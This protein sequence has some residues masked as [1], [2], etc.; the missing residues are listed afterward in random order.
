[1]APA[2]R[3][4][5]GPSVP[6]PVSAQAP[7]VEPT[8]SLAALR[9]LGGR[10]PEYRG[11]GL[12]NLVQTLAQACGAKPS[13]LFPVLDA[14]GPDALPRDAPIVLLVLDGVGAAQL[15]ANPQCET[16]RAHRHAE[17]T[18]VFPPTTASAVTTLATGVAA[19]QHGLTGWFI[20]TA[21]CT[22]PLAPLPF[23]LRGTWCDARGAGVAPE[24]VYT[25]PGHFARLS[26][27][28]HVVH[29]D[30]IVDSLYTR[31]HARGA[32]RL[33]VSSLR[34]LLEASAD[35]VHAGGPR[36]VYA[37]WPGYDTLAHAH[38]PDGEPARAHLAE[39][40]AE[41]RRFL[42]R[43]AGSGSTVIVTADHGFV[44]VSP[45][46]AVA[47]DEHPRVTRV[48]AGPL[49]GE[50]RTAF[51]HARDGRADELLEALGDAIGDA[52]LA[53]PSPELVAAGLFGPGP[54]HPEL[55]LRTGD[56]TVLMREG[57]VLYDRVEGEKPGFDLLGVHGGLAGAEMRIP[58]L[59]ARC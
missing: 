20:R 15:D 30:E 4:A 29:P 25:T 53:L 18:S 41:V 3:A 42:E 56:V 36:L 48:L 11:G 34:G 45:G 40:D 43:L 57:H 8:G 52:G 46:S 23:R 19:Q 9:A 50:P 5:R 28:V 37:Y 33:G 38:G 7:G 49:T 27:P 35:R 1:M 13:A 26:V 55:A 59:L 44:E 22:E 31:H 47:L 21:T 54:A 12:V 32:E 16:L 6:G 51:C 2:N 24:A 10:L 14:L 58:L 39:I 17:L